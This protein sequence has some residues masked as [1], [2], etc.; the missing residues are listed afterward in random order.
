MK[1]WMA[2][3]APPTNNTMS[4]V[5]PQKIAG[6]PAVL[7]SVAPNQPPATPNTSA[8]IAA[9][10]T[11]DE[12]DRGVHSLH[13]YFLRPGDPNVPILYEVD[14]IRDGRSFSTRR[15][16]AIQHGRAIFNLQA[17][18][19]VHEPGQDFQRPMPAGMPDPQTLP[20]FKERM[21][22]YREMLGDFYDR[23]RPID[24]RYVTAHPL[25]RNGQFSDGQ[26]VW[27][28][29]ADHLRNEHLTRRQLSKR[30]HLGRVVRYTLDHAALDC[31]GAACLADV[32]RK[33][34]RRRNRI[35]RAERRRRGA[36]QRLHDV[37]Q[38]RALGRAAQQRVLHN[39]E[40]HVLGPQLCAKRVEVLHRQPAVVSEH[41]RLRRADQLSQSG[42]VLFFSWRCHILVSPPPT[43]VLIPDGHRAARGA[44][45]KSPGRAI[46]W[47]SAEA[48]PTR[49][50]ERFPG[51]RSTLMRTLVNASAGRAAA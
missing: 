23:P 9:S 12:P 26:T 13:A 45:E 20:D 33:Q 3:S 1:R 8:L 17:S 32:I 11:V 29:A 36:F 31:H 34:P 10:R 6:L 27:L 50:Q 46:I 42:H 38:A 30:G 37:R 43:P 24:L 28:K 22:P 14:R 4:V 44:H 40:H 15:V 5:P 51:S 39:R 47:P 19:H 2:Y 21:A 35:L 48:R 18:F 25:E 16:V 7:S 49:S 41:H